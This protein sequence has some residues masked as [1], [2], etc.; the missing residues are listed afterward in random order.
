MFALLLVLC[1]S[2]MSSIV[3]AGGGGRDGKNGKHDDGGGE[4]ELMRARIGDVSLFN[5]RADASGNVVV[6]FANRVYVDE[7]FVQNLVCR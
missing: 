7:G 4:S 6:F 3:L 2:L 1:S 5:E